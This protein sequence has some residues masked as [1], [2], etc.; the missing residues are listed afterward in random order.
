MRRASIV[1]V[2][3]LG[4]VLSA[5]PAFASDELAQYLEGQAAAH[6]SGE[7]TVVC[8]TPDGTISE[9]TF[10]RQ[11]AGV[12]VVEDA[13]G[14]VGVTR[15]S[16]GRNWALGD[17]YRVEFVR[18]DSFESRS[19]RVVE[20][21]EGDLTRVVLFFD[22]ASGALFASDVHNGD[23]SLY[24]SSRFQNFDA[25]PPAMSPD[26]VMGRAAKPGR[27]FTGE[28]E[29]F[30]F[31]ETLAGFTLNEVYLGPTADVSNGYYGDG[32]FSFTIFVSER[33]IRVPE[34]ADAPV[35]EIRG[36]HYQRQFYPGSVILSWE[37]KSGGFVLVGDLP[38][39]LQE[40]VLAELPKP[41]KPSFFVRFWRELFG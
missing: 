3:V 17:Q 4:F 5:G 6:F 11:A 27:E 36:G 22:R 41:G 38:L 34:L 37:A 21:M 30:E 29:A 16:H 14:A 13:A 10:V 15:V 31:P 25:A 40:D 12:R 7:Q 8:N 33:A 26:L 18:I 28:V 19:V 1:F 2:L 24:C 20:V 23:G 32:I 9:V 39:D 35:V